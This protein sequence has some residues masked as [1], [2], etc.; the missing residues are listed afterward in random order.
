MAP[1][2]TT[3]LPAL[4]TRSPYT[5]GSEY[6]S[7]ARARRCLN[8]RTPRQVVEFN[9]IKRCNSS[10]ALSDCVSGIISLSAVWDPIFPII[11]RAF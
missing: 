1:E 4:L 10:V 5:A 2:S 6:S 8:P 11:N 9:A 3:D 7:D